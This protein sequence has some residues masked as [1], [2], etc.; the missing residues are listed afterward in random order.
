[1][2]IIFKI[3]IVVTSAFV[4]PTA[5]CFANDNALVIEYKVTMPEKMKKALDIFDP[6]FRVWNQSDFAPII[7]KDVYDFSIKQAPSA[8]IGDFNGDN[9]KDIALFGRNKTK[10]SIICI[11]SD[12][13]DFKVFEMESFNLKEPQDHWT[14]VGPDMK[15]YGFTMYM[16][17]HESG[18][19]QSPYE[20]NSLNLSTDAVEIVYF[21][22]AAKIFYFENGAFYEYW[23]AD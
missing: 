14:I 19:I 3:L 10:S 16:T 1:M 2:N 20:E 22:K 15:E 7:I 13:K 21:E 17:Y 9:L 11:L 6:D 12:G 5:L 23:T 18:L 8:V 4:F